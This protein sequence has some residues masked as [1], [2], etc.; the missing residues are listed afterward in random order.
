M[1]YKLRQP[2][3]VHEDNRGTLNQLV[4]EGFSQV[5][6]ITSK[7]GAARGGH[8]HK[9]NT[10]AFYIISGN[11]TVTFSDGTAEEACSFGPGSFFEIPAYVR[12]SFDFLEDTVLVSMYSRG[13][14]DQDG[15]KDIYSE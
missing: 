5:N 7:K 15:G 4:R 1:L 8:Y 12:H 13:V 10:E 3:F 11:V 14:E 2:D 9:R 6:V